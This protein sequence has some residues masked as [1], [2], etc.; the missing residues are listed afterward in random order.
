[1]TQRKLT[2][3]A[4][5]QQHFI[6]QLKQG[7]QGKYFTTSGWTCLFCAVMSVGS[8]KLCD[9]DDEYMGELAIDPKSVGL[10]INKNRIGCVCYIAT[11]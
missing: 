8:I 11:V 9:A 7:K 10:V 4:D 5:V 6:S 1:M 2:F 3:C